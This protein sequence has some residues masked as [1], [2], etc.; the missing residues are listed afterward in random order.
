MRHTNTFFTPTCSIDNSK[1]MPH[2]NHF[3][4]HHLTAPGRW[5]WDSSSFF[6][7]H[8]VQDTTAAVLE[9][10]KR[11]CVCLCMRVSGGGGGFLSKAGLYAVMFKLK[12]RAFAADWGGPSLEW[13]AVRKSD[14]HVRVCITHSHM[15][16]PSL[17]VHTGSFSWTRWSDI[18]SV[19]GNF[20]LWPSKKH[21][22][23]GTFPQ[24]WIEGNFRLSFHP[25]HLCFQT[26]VSKE[27]LSTYMFRSCHAIGTVWCQS[28]D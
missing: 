14:S 10:Y 15:H 5:Y 6:L 27:P 11:M 1:C 24:L 7:P 13:R 28:N 23:I 20:I 12:K 18:L 19:M 25:L 17:L 8:A 26:N 3:F 4:Q 2:S 21:L 9:D 16:W 22:E